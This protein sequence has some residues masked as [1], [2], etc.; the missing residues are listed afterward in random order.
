MPNFRSTQIRMFCK[1]F[2]IQMI[3]YQAFVRLESEHYEGYLII[4]NIAIVTTQQVNRIHSLRHFFNRKY[5]LVSVAQYCE[6]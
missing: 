3:L 1:N 4:K 5:N 2:Q 6:L